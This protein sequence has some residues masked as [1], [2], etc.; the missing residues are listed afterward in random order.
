MPA[1]LATRL[2]GS[3]GRP[4]QSR[5]DR[6]LRA[7][8][9][10]RVAR[11]TSS[12]AASLAL[13]WHR[14]S[15]VRRFTAAAFG[16]SLLAMLALGSWVTGKIEE[17]VVDNAAASTALYIGHFIAPHLQ[18]LASSDELPPRAIDALDEVMASASVRLRVAAIKIWRHD[19]R[20][21]YSTQADLI[22]ERYAP[23]RALLRAWSG[24]VAA[25]FDRV[26]GEES[27]RERASGLKLLE[28]YAP[29]R[30]KDTG[31]VIAV[32]EFY[33]HADDLYDQLV[34]AKW[35]SWLIT[36]LLAMAMIGALFSIVADGS[37]T[38]ERQRLA[39]TQRI[40]DLTGLL[41]QNRLLR[42][43]IERGAREA[44]EDNERFLRGIGSDLHDGPAQLIGLALLRLDSLR[45][46][47]LDLD[48]AI[49]RSALSDGLE[50][51]RHISA[52]LLLP[53]TQDRNLNE[54]LFFTI[55]EHERR[56]RTSVA[57]DSR[58]LPAEP[59]RYVKICACRF[60]Q[61]GLTNAFRHAAGKGQRV[62]A[63]F[64]EKTITVEVVD[65]G[66]GM[67]AG[68]PPERRMRLG[69]VGLRG[70]IESIGGTMTVSSRPEG[71]TRLTARLPVDRGE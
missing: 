44:T 66:P 20:I 4:G 8:I 35:Q 14:F 40:S 49:I 29:V 5:A 17:S 67:L 34:L 21:L 3:D 57:F 65:E 22:G 62:S 60:V 54:A 7:M 52:G 46:A 6:G 26:G 68:E 37:R 13:V 10:R 1:R 24:A 50:E 11:F 53:G 71:G 31:E 51:I 38:I 33:E 64:D 56:T 19:G 28:V 45:S 58:G 12:L 43:R 2:F 41:A 47:G 48:T 55:R 69:L 27:A 39:L 70:R 16:V 59:P 32:A 63:R 25:E 15:L 23:D 61:E 30:A 36:A 9:G 18:G 42:D